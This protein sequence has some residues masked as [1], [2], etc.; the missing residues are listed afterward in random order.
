MSPQRIEVRVPA[1]LGQ[2][3]W[4]IYHGGGLLTEHD[5]RQLGLSLA[6]EWNLLAIES[7]SDG[8]DIALAAR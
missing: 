2:L 3:L 7:Q 6:G 1:K 8:I 4:D 5:K